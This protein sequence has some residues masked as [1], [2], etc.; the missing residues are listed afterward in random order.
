[1]ALLLA[2]GAFGSLAQG[3]PLLSDLA[4]VDYHEPIAPEPAPARPLPTSFLP[5]PSDV[6][7]VES[8]VPANPTAIA[9]ISANATS[10]ANATGAA[11]ETAHL[12]HV[13]VP[14]PDGKPYFEC[15]NVSSGHLDSISFGV[16]AH[17]VPPIWVTAAVG[18]VYMLA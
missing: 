7:P 5:V 9:S 3:R 17:A 11:N 14:C 4:P 10:P 13:W 8:A 15:R 1:M 18:A 6:V 16:L 2:L 12:L